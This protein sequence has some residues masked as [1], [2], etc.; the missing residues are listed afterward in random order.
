MLRST[1]ALRSASLKTNHGSHSIVPSKR[2]TSFVEFE[3]SRSVV[4]H[5]NS[6]KASENLFSG[7]CSTRLLTCIQRALSPAW[8]ER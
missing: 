8:H 7:P 3:N 1:L 5:A 4:V 2:K 6:R